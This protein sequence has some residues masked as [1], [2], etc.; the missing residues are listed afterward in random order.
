MMATYEKIKAMRFHLTSLESIIKEFCDDTGFRHAPP[1]SIGQYPRIRLE[2]TVSGI[3]QWLDLSLGLDQ[4][5]RKFEVF[6]PSLPYEL[7]AG[8]FVDMP[9]E[10]QFGHRF[11]R[12]WTVFS[13]RPFSDV[14]S[15][16]YAEL[17]DARKTLETWTVE[18]IVRDGERIEL[19]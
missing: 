9:D 12:R 18:D 7:G 11:S 5:G 15:S 10:S 19:G 8:A 4:R 14:E 1:L 17:G 13:A 3:S 16:L 2:R 6:D